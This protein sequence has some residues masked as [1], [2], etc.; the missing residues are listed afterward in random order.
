MFCTSRNFGLLLRDKNINCKHLEIK[1]SEKHL[2]LEYEVREE[3]RALHEEL[4]NLY[5]YIVL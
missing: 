2:D 5:T 4:R 3:F 1:Y